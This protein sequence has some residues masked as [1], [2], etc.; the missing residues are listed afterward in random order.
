MTIWSRLKA[1]LRF[2]FRGKRTQQWTG[3]MRLTNADLVAALSPSVTIHP[4]S[5]TIESSIRYNDAAIAQ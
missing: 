2:R 1:F 3:T 4:V 5:V